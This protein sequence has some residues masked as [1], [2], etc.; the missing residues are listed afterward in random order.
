MTRIHDGERGFKDHFLEGLIAAYPRY[1]RR[2]PDA[3]AVMAADSPVPGQVSVIIG[4]G[5]GHYPAFAG[6]VGPGLCH[7][8]VVG[9]VFTSPSATQAYRAIEALDGGAGVLLSFGNYSGDVMHF[10]LAA[11]QARAAGIDTRVVLV[12]DDVASRPLAEA[13][14]RRGIAGGFFVFRAGAAAAR[15]GDDIASVERVA[16]HANERTRTFGIAL[17]GCTFPGRS[18]PLFTV[19]PDT[20]A[21]GL[22]IHGEPGIE[23]IPWVPARELAPILLEPLLR[24]RPDGARRARVLLNGLGS[25]KY[26]EL[27]VLYR[28]IHERLLGE[29]VE[30]VDV[31][32]GEFVT[33]LDMA[34]CSLTLCWLD[35][36][37]ESLLATPAA[38]PG[39]RSGTLGAA[40]TATVREPAPGGPSAS[41]AHAG[42]G[43][44]TDGTLVVR[45]ALEAVR[46]A[47]HAEVEELGRLDAVV[48]DGDHGA[49]MARGT[50]AAV[51]AADTAVTPAS[52]LTS[53]GAA[54]G[55]A[56][57]GASGALW[58]AGLLA[59]GR[60]MGERTAPDACPGVADIR[61]ALVEALAV[62]Q[63]LGGTSLGDRTLVDALAPFVDAFPAAGVSLADAWEAALP[64]MHAAVESTAHLMPRKG[65]AAVHGAH[66]L[67]TVDA[68]ARSL[69]I[70]L[71]AVAE[72]LRAAERDA[73]GDR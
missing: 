20:I 5:S 70:A 32:V 45:R 48:G 28:S 29:G 23:S 60:V 42:I 58:G 55:D 21:L 12:T 3:S 8:A 16:R 46:D 63:R 15:R 22:G 44:P 30:P 49:G 65:R 11:E 10:G 6:L 53:A 47:I 68:G 2:V 64:P 59:M 18:E 37:L 19:D 72:V 41:T 35:D 14:Q 56:A 66:A 34:G 61:A 54:F 36:E 4:G 9:D 24:E 57:G 43:E 71:A 67:G 13:A 52:A 69:G 27:F 51:A 50:D 38:A 25:S 40:L 26:E 62:I 31:E 73:G 39:Y 1:L 33:S 7:G 17:A